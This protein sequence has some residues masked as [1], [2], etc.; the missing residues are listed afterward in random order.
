[1]PQF[2]VHVNPNAASRGAAPYLLDI[3]NDLLEEMATRVVVPL[4]PVAQL[5][6]RR[7]PS[8]MP[9]FEIGGID[10]AMFTPHLAGVQAKLLGKPIGTLA[11][12]RSEIVAAVDMLISGI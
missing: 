9:A 8:L 10:Y 12:R 2:A 3:Q 6:H 7:I 1:M 5:G 11:H 4:R